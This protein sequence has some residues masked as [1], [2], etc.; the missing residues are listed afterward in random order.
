MQCEIRGMADVAEAATS[1]AD[2]LPKPGRVNEVCREWLVK[3]DGALAVRLQNEE[4][5][6]EWCGIWSMWLPVA[7]NA[8]RQRTATAAPTLA[9]RINSEL[10][11][12]HSE[13]SRLHVT[14]TNQLHLLKQAA[15]GSPR[16]LLSRLSDPTLNGAC[17]LPRGLRAE[18][19][20]EAPSDLCH[21]MVS[22]LEGTICA[23]LRQL[24]MAVGRLILE[25]HKLE[26]AEINNIYFQ[27]HYTGNKSRNA[28]VREDFPRAQDEQRREE[29]TAAAMRVMYHQMVLQQEEIDASVAHNLAQR[30]K[31]EEE[32]RRRTLEE[33]DEEVAKK[34]QLKEVHT[35]LS[36]YPVSHIQQKHGTV[37]VSETR[38]VETMGV[39]FAR[40]MFTVAIL[41][42][43][44]RHGVMAV[45]VNVFTEHERL[46]IAHRQRE[47]REAEARSPLGDLPDVALSRYQRDINSV[48]LPLP[49]EY[50][51]DNL[52]QQFRRVPLTIDDTLICTITDAAVQTNSGY[53]SPEDGYAMDSSSSPISPA[54]SGG[55]TEDEARRL[56]EEKDEGVN[57]SS[58]PLTAGT[59]PVAL[60][61]ECLRPASD[62][63]VLVTVILVTRVTLELARRLQEEEQGAQQQLSMLDQDRLMAIEAQD[64]ELARLL[65]ER[66]RAKAKRARE[67]AKQKALLKKQQH[68]G[69]P[70][71][72]DDE[73]LAMSPGSSGPHSD[74]GDQPIPP[75]S[76][77]V[78]PTDLDLA[79]PRKPRQRFP[80]PEAIEVLSCSPEAGPSHGHTLPNIAMAIDPTYPRRARTGGSELYASSSPVMSPSVQAYEEDEDSPVPPYMPIQGQRRTMSLEKKGRK[81]K[82]KDGCKQQ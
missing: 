21:A 39:K 33:Q 12:V 2:T 34:L 10:R 67:R 76:T 45:H 9:V 79:G 72:S 7:D 20:G 11:R 24:R 19:A 49:E 68:S 4:C 52:S 54:L 81:S 42:A 58:L 18:Y 41:K 32:E 23:E 56:Q 3:E 69:G 44:W 30:L 31:Q 40:S 66:E 64:K 77:A 47:C 60:K 53:T 1:S 48:G 29:E 43:E 15:G 57:K 28:Q 80:D 38:E 78:R 71:V 74:W 61:D 82:S 50:L 63:I 36:L 55:L 26:S 59:R 62:T 5:K 25:V 22:R 17:R 75:H 6:K 13:L 8:R 46:R 35:G 51:Q 27:H 37:N 16:P 14:M 70:G 65:Q 73:G